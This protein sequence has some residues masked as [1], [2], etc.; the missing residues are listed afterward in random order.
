MKT[1]VLFQLLLYEIHGKKY[2]FCPLPVASYLPFSI[3]SSTFKIEVVC[4]FSLSETISIGTQYQNLG[5]KPAKLQPC[6]NLHLSWTWLLEDSELHQR[7]QC[8]KKAS[9]TTWISLSVDCYFSA[10]YICGLSHTFCIPFL[11]VLFQCVLCLCLPVIQGHSKWKLLFYC[12]FS[13]P[14]IACMSVGAPPVSAAECDTWVYTAEW[15]LYPH[16]AHNFI[17]L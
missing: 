6:V 13:M 1:W 8:H 11:R 3:I 15:R 5:K 14:Q 4:S 10:V 2:N 16:Q 12:N 17:P 7:K 9:G